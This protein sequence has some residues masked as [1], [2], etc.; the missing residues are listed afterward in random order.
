[1]LLF[2]KARSF[3]RN[4]FLSRRVDADLDQEV[5]AH[6]ELL[7]EEKTRAGMPP[8]EAQRAA[9]M[10]LGGIE[11][12][13]EQV[14]DSRTGALF[15]SLLQDLRYALR[16]M[17]RS[18]G[19]ALTAVLI[20]T[21]GIAANVIVFGVLQALVLRHLDVPHADR[22][23]TLQPKEG[24]PFLSYPEMRDV[25]DDNTVFSAVA[26]VEIQEFGLEANGVTRHVW[27]NEVS[28]QYFEALGIK[29]FLGRLL[30]RADDDH[31]RASDAAVLSWPAWN[32]DFGADPNIVGRMVRIDKHPYTIVG[33]T[34]E[35]FFGTERIAQPDLFVPMANEASLDGVNW[36]ESRSHKTVFSLVCIKDGVTLPQVQA[37]LNTIAARIARQYPKEEEGLALKLARPGLI[38]D[39]IGGPARGFLAGVMG[40]AGIVLLAACANLGSL[41]AAR[42]ADRTREIAIR[43]AIGASRWRIFRQVLVEAIVISIFG[44]ACACGLAW[45]ALS[46]LANWHPPTRFPI[47]FHVLPEPSLILMT[48]LISVLAGVLFGLMPLRLIFRTDPNEAIKSGGSPSSS[49]R[50]WA[51]RDVLLAAQIALCCVAVTAAFVSLRGLGKALTMDLGFKAQNAVRTQFELSRAGYTRDAADHFQRQLLES[52]SQIPGVE[53][54]GYANT[55]PLSFEQAGTPVFTQQSVDFRPS[56]KAFDTYFYDVSPGY[57]AASGTQLLAGRDV[58]FADTAKTPAIAIVNQ[59]FARRLFHSEHAVG[60]YF[61]NRSGVSIQIVGIMADGKHFTLSEDPEPAAFF[62][63]SQQAD[64]RTSLIVRTRRDTA[65]MVASIREVVR[66]LDPGVAIQESGPWNTQ[67]ALSFFPIQVATVALGLFGAF[68]L[69]LSIAGTFGLASYTVSKRLREL[70]IRVALGAQAKQILSAALGRML[71]LLASG[72]VV[73]VLLG[74]AASR[75]LAAIVY[76]ASAQDPFVLAAVAFTLLLTGSLS[77]A[78]PVRRVLR[79]DPATLLREQ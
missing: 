42:T 40:L 79:V 53:A 77:V 62:P 63:I 48:V 58:S 69:L 6:L 70:A 14:R 44:G 11:Q 29:P 64:T 56:N 2:A 32:S 22:V 5:H 19:F 7:I 33:V 24:G 31:P 16:Q 35:G 37:D 61:K 10:E 47:R 20:L 71:I 76:Q 38:G 41:F 26:G 65:D 74:V 17:R 57:M 13:K 27:G 54:A 8:H 18:P 51:L 66:D 50:R 59:E 60:R 72:S 67:L 21:L 15:D 28:G 30:E 45:M 49:S 43:I 52:V 78:G 39:F 4:L 1:M 12:V 55:T 73:G 23:M 75:L 36:L 46:G 3:L 25:R 68:G 34:P 9:R